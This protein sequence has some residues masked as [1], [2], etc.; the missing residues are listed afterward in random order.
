MIKSI[1]KKIG[2]FYLNLI[3]IDTQKMLSDKNNKVSFFKKEKTF[4]LYSSKVFNSVCK[5]KKIANEYT[6]PSPFLCKVRDVYLIGPCGIP[7]KQGGRILQ[8]KSRKNIFK[9][10]RRTIYFMGII[11]FIKQYLLTFLPI[12]KYDLNSGFLLMPVHGY[13]LDSPNYCHWLLEQLPMLYAYGNIKEKVKIITNKTLKKFQIHSLEMMGFSNEKI[14]KHNSTLTLVRNLY[15]TKLRN[16]SSRFSERDPEGR[17][18]ASNKLKSKCINSIEKSKY[19]KIFISRQ[20]QKLKVISNM[21]EIE[22]ILKKYE[23]EILTPGQKTLKE[24]IQKFA[25]AKLI[26]APRGAGLANMIFAKEN[27]H[28]IEIAYYTKWEQDIFYLIASEFNYSFDSVEAKRDIDFEG[29]YKIDM[30]WKV[31]PK[32]LEEAILR[33][34]V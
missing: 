7:V 19:R 13:A 5:Y 27:C 22:P 26:V 23:I 9:L 18:W 25:E 31:N 14:H 10:L 15:I 33:S 4:K 20:D 8:L 17:S 2:Y 28:I 32:L 21:S 12:K 3:L 24:D 11:N 6:V 29:K 34:S 30:G 1:I 16:A